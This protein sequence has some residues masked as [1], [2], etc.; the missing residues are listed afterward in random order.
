MCSALII[1]TR[2]EF[3][4]EA[5]YM[6]AYSLYLDSPEYD[7]DQTNTEDA[8]AA[9]QNFLNKYPRSKYREQAS[10]LI[11]A[12]QVKL[13]KKAFENAYLYYKLQKYLDGEALKAA[14]ISFD[15]FQND[16]PDSKF[17]EEVSYLKIECAYNMAKKSIRSKQEDRLKE[18][19]GYY[20]Y[21]VDKF[22]Q[23]P[24]VR[25][26]ENLYNSI[27]NTLGKLKANNM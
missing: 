26:A 22:P 19:V 11:D 4:E 17:N 7:L 10:N 15:N 5:L 12:M 1:S 18:A 21:F 14:I 3:A 23:S 2:S 16:F 27:Q 25:D 13:E 6:Y 20:Y 9:I 24:K 8:I